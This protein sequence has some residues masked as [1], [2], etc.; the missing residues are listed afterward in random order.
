MESA[1]DKVSTTSLNPMAFYWE[2]QH[3]SEE[4]FEKL[5]VM[6]LQYCR[7][8]SKSWQDCIDNQEILWINYAKKQETNIFINK[9][10]LFQ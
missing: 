7:Q 3:I 4:I 1:A 5:D 9:N 2:F 6:S 10:E 8:V